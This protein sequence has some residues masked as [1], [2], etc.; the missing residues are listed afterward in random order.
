M[1]VNMYD[2]TDL[3]RTTTI[4]KALSSVSLILDDVNLDET[5]GNY[6][7]LNVWGRELLGRNVSTFGYIPNYDGAVIDDYTY[8]PREITVEY[9]IK[10]DTNENFRTAFM[11]LNDALHKSSDFK[12][13]FTDDDNYYFKGRL[14][15]VSQPET[16]TNTAVGTFILFCQ[17]PYAYGQ[18]V[19]TSMG[20][21]TV[22][23]VS[24]YRYPI[25]IESLEIDLM[26]DTESIRIVNSTTGKRIVLNG[27]YSIGDKII[28][29]D[30]SIKSNN[31][32]IINDLDYMTSNFGTFEIR[33]GDSITVSPSSSELSLQY[34]ERAL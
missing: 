21:G 13:S 27:N 8:R 28:Y 17:D 29:D 10:A 31:I 9:M 4:S 18:S 6:K 2:F 14:A 16:I 30:N 24:T 11:E 3:Y 25:M 26:E 19:K 1:E 5:L 7:T 32:N 12:I 20:N 15:E 34:R 22:D 23:V 33:D